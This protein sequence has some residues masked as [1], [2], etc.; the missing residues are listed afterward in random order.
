MIMNYR[1]T[2]DVVVYVDDMDHF[3]YDKEGKK[4]LK[5]FV[6]FCVSLRDHS[7]LKHLKFFP[8]MDAAYYYI[9]GK[10]YYKTLNPAGVLL[11]INRVLELFEDNHVKTPSF[12][13]RTYKYLK[14]STLAS[15][16]DPV[17]TRDHLCLQNGILDLSNLELKP[18][19]P[20]YFLISQLPYDWNP[21]KDFPL[22]RRFLSEFCDHQEDRMEFIR[23]SL[24]VLVKQQIHFQIFLQIVG[25]GA[26]GKSTLATVATCLVGQDCTITTSLQAL[27]S[28]PFE[29]IN[30]VGKK[31]ILISDSER[32]SGDLHI[33]K[34]IVGGDALKGRLKH[35]QGA[36]EVRPEGMVWI[37]TNHPLVSSDTTHAV[38][39]RMRIFPALRRSQKRESLL[40]CQR[41]VWR[42]PLKEEMTGILNWVLS[43][44][45]SKVQD[46]IERTDLSVPSLAI[47]QEDE[48][49]KLNPIMTW[50]EEEV[51]IL[52]HGEEGG[53]YVGFLP[54]GGPKAVLEESRR[55]ALYPAYVFWS[56]RL[57]L[58]PVGHRRFL[59]DLVTNLS[60]K[61][62]STSK[63]R[64]TAGVFIQG[65]RLKGHI[66][67][68]D[69]MYG[70]PLLSGQQELP[71][72]EKSAY[73][74][75]SRGEQHRALTPYLYSKYMESLEKT[76][77]KVELNA[78]SR[79][80]DVTTLREELTEAFVSECKVA[81]VEYRNSAS[82]VI[83]ASLNKVVKFGG[84]SFKYKPLG[85]SPR[86]IPVAYGDTINSTKRIVRE[87]VYEI[88]ASRA[89][90]RGF[91]LVDLD[92]VSCY[93]SILLGLYPQELRCLQL[94]IEG[95]GLW[96]FIREEFESRG[97]GHLFNK[98]A[99]KVCVYSSF[100][101]GGNRAMING[102]ME[103][104]RKDIGFSESEFRHSA[105]YEECH[106]IARRVTEE[107]MNSA[108]ILDFKSISEYIFKTH[109]NEYLTGPTGHSYFVTE[110]SFKTAYPNYLQSFEFSLLADTTLRTKEMFPDIQVLG[111]YHDGNVLALPTDN[112]DEILAFM[113]ERILALG[114]SLGLGLYPQK[115]EIKRFF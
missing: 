56:R 81:S 82:N 69:Y 92:I 107:M 67:E 61:G 27:H 33:L 68:R 84:I 2:N 103:H 101:Q 57:G 96:K 40:E 15:F 80:L 89:S 76:P 60:V 48:A 100:F 90:E 105:G 77:L 64:K 110:S 36:F 37:I 11:L 108:V 29:L 114:K 52:S 30:L 49:R 66:F 43:M 47:V 98:P 91:T 95:G 3:Y 102:I 85:V 6:E 26:T 75:P 111:H 63:K 50:I 71:S 39:R 1:Q 20:D 113:S 94:A 44:E 99:V 115:L 97:S 87:R 79:L 74:P 17:F 109:D 51:E 31:L 19:S 22:F 112:K 14:Y 25:P 58:R 70:A 13:Q 62:V 65:V 32:F 86:I 35:I 54:D 59:D 45:Y 73:V 8:T 16:D 88:M 41:N 72:V 12:A 24:Y 46:L 38:T 53:S 106:T 4:T 10:G 93:T 104:F 83:E 5:G 42:G 28:D 7:S 21:D 55:M 23:A 18:F 9:T 78:S 34:Q